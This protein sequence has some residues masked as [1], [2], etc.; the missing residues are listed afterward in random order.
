MND[1]KRKMMMTAALTMLAMAGAWAQGP[2]NSGTYYK[3]ADG[4][5]G[6]ALKTALSNIISV[7]KHT[8]SYDELLELYKKTDTRADGY[9]RDWYSNITNFEHIKD[10]AGNYQKEGDVYNREHSVPQSWGAPKTDIVHVVPTDGYVNNRRSSYPFGEV[11]NVTYSSAN[12]YSKL[13]TCRTPGYSKIVFEPNDEV[14]GDLARIYF[15][16]ATCYE[17]TITTWSGDVITGTKYQPYAQWTFDM[18]VR[19]SKL[20]PIDD[21]ERARNAAIARADVQGNRNPFVDYPGLE[22]YIW[23]DKKTVAFSYDNYD[24]G[25][26]IVI[27]RVMQ[28]AFRPGGG[29]FAD[30]V[31]VTI[32]CSTAGATIYYTTDGTDATTNSMVYSSPV[33]LKANTTLKAIATKDGMADSYQTSAS[34]VITTSGTGG[35]VTPSECTIALNNDLFGT[36][37]SG[38]LGKND[39]GTFIGTQDNIV[40]SYA[41]G[42]GSNMYI[43]DSQIRL[44]AGN[45]LTVKSLRGPITTLEFT[46]DPSS[47]SDKTLLTSTGTVSG[48]T[49]TGSAESVTFN[50]NSGSGNLRLTKV[51]VKAG[52]PTITVVGDITGD[53]NVDSAD[54]AALVKC[55]YE[56]TVHGTENPKAD[57]NSDGRVDVA[58]I[59]ALVKIMLD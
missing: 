6:A 32:S 10:K 57:V 2:N 8:P 53:G 28:P 24:S 19:W 20:D 33:K 29:T 25:G 43:N 26:T 11:G 22:D 49:W 1:M 54:L 40:V 30:S 51:K 14:K 39:M 13:G 59:I 3:N 18:L 12:G 31:E 46:I 7:K 17:S 55:I 44:Y 52:S 34:Y 58:D 36:S 21:V 5:S 45:T 56:K 42:T 15:Y 27:E 23:G 50:V 35:E 16:M 4:K 9:V 37:F 48:G 41:K 38:A 47:S